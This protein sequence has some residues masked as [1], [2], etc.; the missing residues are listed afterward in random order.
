MTHLTLPT[1]VTAEKVAWPP[2]CALAAFVP[3]T[4]WGFYPLDHAGVRLWLGCP[5][6]YLHTPGRLVV[7][8]WRQYSGAAPLLHVIV[9]HT[10][11]V[12]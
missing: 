1:R 5:P 4:A 12:H 7:V 8:V 3:V 9:G 6:A 2:S 11:H 10:Q